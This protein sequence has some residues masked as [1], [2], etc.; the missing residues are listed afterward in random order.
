MKVQIQ[1][2]DYWTWLWIIQPQL[3][4]IFITIYL[5]QML[6]L[7]FKEKFDKASPVIKQSD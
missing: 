6:S 7:R 4:K 5:L 2:S 3:P 1:N